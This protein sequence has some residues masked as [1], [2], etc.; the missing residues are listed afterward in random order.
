MIRNTMYDL[1]TMFMVAIFWAKEHGGGPILDFIV[2]YDI[3]IVDM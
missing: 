3:L 2:A 1:T